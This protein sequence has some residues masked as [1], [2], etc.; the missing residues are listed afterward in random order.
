MLSML[1]F[2]RCAGMLRGRHTRCGGSPPTGDAL[3][4]Q[5]DLAARLQQQHGWLG[6]TADPG[7]LPTGQVGS[8]CGS[9]PFMCRHTGHLPPG[10]N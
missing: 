1:P 8:F 10:R 2:L 3:L 7:A 9:L 6:D 5:A 4:Q